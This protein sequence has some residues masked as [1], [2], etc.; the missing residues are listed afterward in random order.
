V[1]QALTFGAHVNLRLCLSQDYAPNGPGS[2]LSRALDGTR[3]LQLC[4]CRG[5]PNWGTAIV[6]PDVGPSHRDRWIP[7]CS[8]IE[9]QR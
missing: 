2:T 3:C 5:Q 8:M 6:R 7:D 9:K 1:A 4:P